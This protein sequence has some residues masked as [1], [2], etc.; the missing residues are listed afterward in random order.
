M[1]GEL[2]DLGHEDPSTPSSCRSSQEVW[3]FAWTVLAFTPEKIAVSDG[4]AEVARFSVR[5]SDLDVNGHVNNTRYAQWILD[6]TPPEA[7]RAWRVERYHCL[8][9]IQVGDA[10]A[11]EAAPLEASSSAQ[12]QII[13]RAGVCP[14]ARTPSPRSSALSK[15]RK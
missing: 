2:A 1:H 8:A 11:I 15:R 14:T 3:I 7:H 12:T 13:S 9:E 10:V 4:L 5:N 6:S